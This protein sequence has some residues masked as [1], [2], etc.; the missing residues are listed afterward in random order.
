MQNETIMPKK[1]TWGKKTVETLKRKFNFSIIES[2][3]EGENLQRKSKRKPSRQEEI[4][5]KPEKGLSKKKENGTNV[6]GYPVESIKAT[7]KEAIVGVHSAEELL[8]YYEDT[9][10]TQSNES[11][12]AQKKS[13]GTMI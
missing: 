5:T 6:E 2:D 9:E 13:L 8:Y 11:N 3:K 4:K 10:M 12:K 1:C 7:S